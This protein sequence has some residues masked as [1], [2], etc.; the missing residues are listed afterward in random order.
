MTIPEVTVY[1][2]APVGEGTV[3]VDNWPTALPHASRGKKEGLTATL[4]MR[5]KKTPEMLIRPG[6]DKVTREPVKGKDGKQVKD[7]D[8]NL[9]FQEYVTF[10]PSLANANSGYSGPLTDD[11]LAFSARIQQTRDSFDITQLHLNRYRDSYGWQ[12]G[13]T[14]KKDA[15]PTAVQG[16]A[17]PSTPEGKNKRAEQWVWEELRFEG[18]SA[19]INAYDSQKLTW[20]RG[21][22][23]ATGGLDPTMKELFRDEDI[24]YAFMEVGVAFEGGSWMAVNTLTGAV[25]TGSNAL[26]IIQT[27]P[28]ILA[29]FISIGEND[30]FKQKIADAQWTGIKAHGTARIPEFALDWPKELVQMVAHITHWG[31]AYGWHQASDGYKQAGGDPLRIIL[32]FISRASG[33]ANKNGAFSIVKNGPETLNNLKSWGSGIG[34]RTIQGNFAEVDLTKTQIYDDADRSGH[35]IVRR[36]HAATDGSMPCYECTP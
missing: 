25:E 24:R 19:S 8:G 16:E 29:A 11:Q 12:Y 4:G 13:G 27:D 22:G 35:F 32:H 28:H 5:V 3:T 36:A 6:I 26:A 1:G 21:L 20:G 14:P 2:Q 18:S 9:L 15:T 30:A 17:D 34:L 23:A 10:A 31:P 7:A 33:G